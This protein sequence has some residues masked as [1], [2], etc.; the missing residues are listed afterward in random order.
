M[1]KLALGALLAGAVLFLAACG[2]DGG[3]SQAAHAGAGGATVAVSSVKPLGG[4]A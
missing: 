4:H 2:G 3:E 1:V